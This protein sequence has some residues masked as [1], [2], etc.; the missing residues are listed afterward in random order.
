MKRRIVAL[1]VAATAMVTLAIAAAGASAAPTPQVVA[2]GLDNPRHLTF[3]ANGDL[4][5]VEAGR[6]GT[7]NCGVNHPALG[8]RASAS[9]VRSRWS[10]T[11]VRTSAS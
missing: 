9:P 5:V 8:R 4:Y 11:T 2:T 1:A 3:S 6:G 7:M 10:A